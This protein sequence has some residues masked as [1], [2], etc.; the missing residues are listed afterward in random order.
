[1]PAAAVLSAIARS[2]K[3]SP[4]S[5][6]TPAWARASASVAK[7]RVSISTAMPQVPNRV[8]APWLPPSVAGPVVPRPGGPSPTC[9]SDL[10]QVRSEGRGRVDPEQDPDVPL[11]RPLGLEPLEVVALGHDHGPLVRVDVLL[12]LDRDH[13]LVRETE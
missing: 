7:D 10:D 4:S 3:R 1:M 6:P 12:G 8:R 11:H 9:A 5:S 2:G 13:A